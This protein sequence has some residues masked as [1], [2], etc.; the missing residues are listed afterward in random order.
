MRN[1]SVSS[2]Q[3]GIAKTV[4]TLSFAPQMLTAGDVN[5]DGKPDVIAATS[6]SLVQ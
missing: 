6:H 4:T 2:G 5:G 1:A 3:F